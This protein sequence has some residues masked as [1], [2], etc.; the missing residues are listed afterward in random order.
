MSYNTNT[1]KQSFTATASQT[2]F[3]FNFKIYVTNNIKVYETPTGQDPNDTND[4][5]I[6]DTDYTVSIDGDNG[7]TVTLNT[8]ATLNDTIVIVRD[9]PKTR[10]TSYVTQGDL[11]ATSLN[12]DQDYQTYLTVDA[13]TSILNVVR[14]PQSAVGV[15]S[16]LPN[17]VGDTYLKWNA[18]GTQLENDTTIPVSVTTTADNA[19]DAN[20]W[21]NE[22]EDAPV[23]VYTSG[24]GVNRSPVVYSALHYNAKASGFNDESELEKW[25]AE[26]KALTSLSYATEAED[27]PVNI[28]TSDG[29]GTFTSTPQAG[30]FSSLHYSLKAAIFNPALY[31][32]KDINTLTAKTTPADADEFAGADSAA[33]FALKKFSFANIKATLKTYFDTLYIT[34][35]GYS[36]SLAT[37]GYIK[38]PAALGGLIIQWGTSANVP[39]SGNLTVA[40]PLAF[41]SSCLS[42][43]CGTF[44]VGNNTVFMHIESK[45]ASNFSVRNG[46]TIAPAMWIAIGH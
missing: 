41:P 4:I 22:A 8:G 14:L 35:T 19:L 39:T 23:K 36:I 3:A 7:G 12:E 24:I 44:E 30:I 1:G 40:F 18:A 25:D 10:T 13:I 31:I 6:L 45:T 11:L 46:D 2:A 5:L 29:D 9:L 33:S 34:L 20:S 32:E 38:L 16:L 43:T 37:D 21:A 17:V 26:A 15:S 27:A 28:V 42:I